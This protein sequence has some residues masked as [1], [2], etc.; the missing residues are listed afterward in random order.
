M[1]TRETS[2]TN[3]MAMRGLAADT[4]AIKRIERGDN[5]S[6]LDEDKE[7]LEL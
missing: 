2:K 6:D 4:E 3:A 1:Q 7:Q 5:H